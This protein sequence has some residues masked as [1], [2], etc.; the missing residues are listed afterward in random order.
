MPDTLSLLINPVVWAIVAVAILCY[1]NLFSG[2]LQQASESDSTLRLV[3]LDQTQSLLNSLP[4]LGLLGTIIGAGI[5][6]LPYVVAQSG[7]IT[8]LFY[9]IVLGAVVLLLHLL[10][11]EVALRTTVKHRLVGYAE[12]YLGNWGKILITFSTVVGIVGALLAYIII[13]GKFLQIVLSPF[14]EVSVFASSIIVW[15]LL[16]LLILRGIHLIAR[17]EFFMN[18][19]LFLTAGLIVFLAVPHMQR[20]NFVLFNQESLFL[21]FGVILFALGGW[22]AIPERADMFENIQ[23]KRSLDNL[24]VWSSIIVVALYLL[25]SVVVV[26]VTGAGTSD[27]ALGGLQPILGEQIL[28]LGA[29]FGLVAIAASVQVLGNSLKNSLR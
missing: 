25:F 1:S 18:I 21:P 16:S 10:M 27:D 22:Q 5:F 12:L 13:G 2:I 23:G 9:F 11:G 17:A 15:L 8:T 6:A 24:I 3:Q 14:F 19:V 29:L 26:G 7:V 20:Q 28:F 4:L